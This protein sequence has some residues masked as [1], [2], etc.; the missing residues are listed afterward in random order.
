[1]PKKKTDP[2]M[3]ENTAPEE[4]TDALPEQTDALPA[5]SESAAEKF[6][7]LKQKTGM[8]FEPDYHC[9]QPLLAIFRFN[10][11]PTEINSATFSSDF[12]S[13]PLRFALP[14][15]IRRKRQTEERNSS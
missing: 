1:M 14:C 12:S 7:P 15:R 3:Q 9:R 13:Y 10:C 11:F 4:A 2:D 5:E 8:E 6:S